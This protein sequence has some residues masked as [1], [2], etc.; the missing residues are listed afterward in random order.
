MLKNPKKFVQIGYL[1][2]ACAMLQYRKRGQTLD[3]IDLKILRCLT[4][5]AKV[6][7]SEIAEKVKLS[8]SAVIERVKKLESNGTIMGY[9]AILDPQKINKDV[10]AIMTV[11]IE[12]PKYNGGFIETVT[13]NPHVTECLYIAGEYDYFLKVV[14]DS[15][16]TLENVLNSIKSIPGVSKTKTNIVFSSPK[17]TVAQP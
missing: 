17:V 15:T 2:Y 16:K 11:A 3:N 12:N 14:T 1:Q 4:K 8:T 10:F 9:T 6:S 5:N 7:Y 13:A